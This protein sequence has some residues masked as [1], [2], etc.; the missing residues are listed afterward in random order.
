MFNNSI[1][2]KQL[3]PKF[4]FMNLGDAFNPKT[5]TAYIFYH[6]KES[7][8]WPWVMFTVWA[9]EI[10]NCV[11]AMEQLH[12]KHRRR[13]RLALWPTRECLWF[14]TGQEWGRTSSVS[15]ER[16]VDHTNSIMATK[17]AIMSPHISTT[18][19]PPIFSMPRPKGKTRQCE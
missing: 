19:I 9:A 8:P 1:H 18:N 17:T 12:H 4:T 14:R 2:S 16:R 13:D 11:K 3:A 15:A 7:N 6:F 10:W 5:H